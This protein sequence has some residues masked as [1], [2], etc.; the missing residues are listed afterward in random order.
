MK[1]SRATALLPALAVVLFAVAACTTP[2]APPDAD[3]PPPPDGV[4]PPVT[5]SFRVVLEAQSV[6]FDR[7]TVT[8]P[9]GVLVTMTFVNDDIVTH[10]FAAYETPAAVSLIYRGDIIRTGTIDYHFNSPVE[11]GTYFFRCDVHPTFM[12]GEF[13]VTE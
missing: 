6:M 5:G 3:A 9:A 7:D 10:N 13:I 4:T 2:A 12:F 8:V 1:T 11:P